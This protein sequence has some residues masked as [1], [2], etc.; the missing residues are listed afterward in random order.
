MPDVVPDEAAKRFARDLADELVAAAPG[1]LVGVYLHGSAVLGDFQPASSDLDLLIVVRDRT[2]RGVVSQI[3]DRLTAPAGCPGVGLEATVVDESPARTSA[4]PWSYRVHVTTAPLDRK[5]VWCEAGGGDSDLIL[6][7]AV[8]RAAG[9][10][11]YG[12]PPADVVGPIEPRV[13]GRQLA[14][15]L[16][17]A[18]DHASESYIVLNACRALRFSAEGLLCSKASGG[19]WALEQGIEPELIGR[20]LRARRDDHDASPGR[21][22][23][24]FASGVA[25]GLEHAG[26]AR[27]RRLRAERRRRSER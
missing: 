4:S 15:E 3:A 8:V 13:V 26:P 7:Y 10:A 1:R 11:A 12:P 20:A 16:R 14:A 18:V 5:T 2:S 21:D 24:S 17:W 6:H 23:V 25:A 27:G 22:A 9:W 19:T